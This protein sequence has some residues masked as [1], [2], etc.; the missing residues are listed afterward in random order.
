MNL[1]QVVMTGVAGMLLGGLSLTA[2]QAQGAFATFTSNGAPAPGLF[3]FTN[4]GVNSTFVSGP[5][6]VKAA[7]NIDFTFNENVGPYLSWQHNLG[8]TAIPG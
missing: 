6:T 8:Y 2:S 7:T 1:R 4:N 3:T 5:G